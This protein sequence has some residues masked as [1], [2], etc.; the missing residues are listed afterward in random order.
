[1]CSSDLNEPGKVRWTIPQAGQVGFETR[2]EFNK[3]IIKIMDGLKIKGG[4]INYGDVSGDCVLIEGS[5]PGPKK[6][7]IRLRHSIRPKKTYP[8]DMKYVSIDSKQ[9]V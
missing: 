4:F 9:G 1:V 7:M 6:R 5:V 3:K 2:T 8:A